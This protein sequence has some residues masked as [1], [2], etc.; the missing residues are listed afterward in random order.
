M[1]L[2]RAVAS[3]AA[4]L[5]VVPAAQAEPKKVSKKRLEANCETPRWS[6]DG[7]KLSY[8]FHA[9]KKDE[10]GV[11][12]IDMGSKKLAD[13]EPDTGP[14]VGGFDE[15]KKPAVKMLVWHPEGRAYVYSSTGGRSQFNLYMEGEGCLTCDRAFG[16]GNKIHPT[17]STDG[18]WLAYAKEGTDHGEVFVVDIFNLEKGPKQVTEHDEDTSYQPRFSP[19]GKRLLFSRFN[20]DRSDNDLYLLDDFQKGKSTLRRL[21][22]MSGAELNA[23]WSPDGSKVAFY[24]V[25]KKKKETRSDLCVTLTDGSTKG[26][27]LVRDVIKPDRANPVWTPDGKYLVFVK[28]HPKK[29]DPL[30]WVEYETKQKGVIKTGTELN[31]D[32]ALYAAGGSTHLCW[33]AQGQSRDQKKRWKKIYCDTITIP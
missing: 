16:F 5:L 31:G 2:D 9:P 21:T 22:K 6:H 7:K 29:H 17:W 20:P 8:E 19:D 1:R 3:L 27:R 30:M 4:V 18:K 23:S 33:K 14:D 10:R 25:Y 24:N 12:V 11:T 28:R 32:P 15:G 26:I 13:V